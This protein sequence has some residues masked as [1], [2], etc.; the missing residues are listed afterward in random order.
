M[1]IGSERP[2]HLQGNWLS[3]TLSALEGGNDAALT[4]TYVMSK[5]QVR[6]L[7]REFKGGEGRSA[8]S[9]LMPVLLCTGKDAKPSRGPPAE[10][11]AVQQP[12]GNDHGWQKPG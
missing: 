5:D 12:P 2:A 1:G 7:V 4:R 6:W 3:R 11:E 10:E 9:R 8:I